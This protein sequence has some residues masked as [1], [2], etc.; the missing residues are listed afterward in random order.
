MW[1]D[2]KGFVQRC[3]A[4]MLTLEL[5]E[6]KREEGQGLVEYGL[7]IGLVSVALIGAL[8]ALTGALNGVFAAIQAALE[9]A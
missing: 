8:G 7:I 9:G 3:H 2:L 6:L 1:N 4:R 5:G